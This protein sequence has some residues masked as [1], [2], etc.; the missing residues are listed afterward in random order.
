MSKLF[1]D[2]NQV[3]INIQDVKHQRELQNILNNPLKR[4]VNQNKNKEFNKVTNT[5]YNNTNTDIDKIKKTLPHNNFEIIHSNSDNIIDLDCVDDENQLNNYILNTN[6]DYGDIQFVDNNRS[7]N[8]NTNPDLR[9][10]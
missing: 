5:N 10:N 4:T 8:Y 2:L 9:N 1:T 7:I 3:R 6:Q